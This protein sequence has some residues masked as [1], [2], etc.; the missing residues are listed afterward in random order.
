MYQ[1]HETPYAALCWIKHVWKYGFFVASSAL[2]L[3]ALLHGMA[4]SFELSS[5]ASFSYDLFF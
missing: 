3:L 5:H 2:S 1:K 4:L